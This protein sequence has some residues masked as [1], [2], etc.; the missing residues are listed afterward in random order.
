MHKHGFIDKGV[1]N[2]FVIQKIHAMDVSSIHS[3]GTADA[4]CTKLLE[5]L[6]IDLAKI[7]YH[8]SNCCDFIIQMTKW[9][10]QQEQ[11]QAFAAYLSW[12][13]KWT[14]HHAQEDNVDIEG[15]VEEEV[16][17][18]QDVVTQYHIA[19]R[20]PFPHMSLSSLASQFHAVDFLPTLEAFIKHF[21]PHTRP[22]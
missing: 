11:L 1:H 19:K 22:S 16:Q 8:A 10:T 6:H 3:L 5:R 2:H 4:Y 20:S 21:I 12:H 13:I 18:K 7:G 15:L 9:I 17:D 14:A